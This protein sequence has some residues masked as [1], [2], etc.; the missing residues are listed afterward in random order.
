MR[1]KLICRKVHVYMGNVCV[2]FLCVCAGT[3]IQVHRCQKKFSSMTFHLIPLRLGSLEP[4]VRRVWARLAA[5]A[6]QQPSCHGPSPPTPV[7]QGH[8][9]TPG[10]HVGAGDPYSGLH[11]STA[12]TLTRTVS[13]APISFFKSMFIICVLCTSYL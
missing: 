12:D 2:M 7:F 9:T 5:T 3:H 6:P 10:F 11:A 13:P 1:I 4:V 8:M